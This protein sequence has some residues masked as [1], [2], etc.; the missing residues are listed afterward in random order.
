[1]TSSIFNGEPF[2]PT[3]E[4]EAR[5]SWGTGSNK[6]QKRFEDMSSTLKEGVYDGTIMRLTLTFKNGKVYTY[7]GVP[8]EVAAELFNAPSAGKYC[9][10]YIF[11][12]YRG[13]LVVSEEEK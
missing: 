7:A 10:Q 2:L 11:R 3:V 8:S 5:K 13:T 4:E 1:M 6:L 9:H 12:Q